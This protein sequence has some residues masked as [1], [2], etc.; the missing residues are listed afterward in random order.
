MRPLSRFAFLSI[1]AGSVAA[2]ASDTTAP[3]THALTNTDA[4]R[5][6]TQLSRDLSASMSVLAA[7][8][9]A[10]A[11]ASTRGAAARVAVAFSRVAGEPGSG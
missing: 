2:C 10:G 1:L 11:V 9:N 5:I 6:G 3:A 4:T 8:G 7:G